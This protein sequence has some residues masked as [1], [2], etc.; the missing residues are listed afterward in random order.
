MESIMRHL[1]LAVTGLAFSVLAQAQQYPARPVKIVTSFLPGSSIDV[2]ARTIAQKLSDTWHQAVT[3]ESHPGGGG[4]GSVGADYVAKSPA[5]GYTWML[6]PNSVMIIGPHLVK[7]PFD[8]FKDFTPAGQVAM[9]PFLL[10]V[11][12]S[13][14]VKNVAELVEY[15][16]ANPR[17]LNYGSAGNG[18][19][20][21]LGAELIKR[22]SGI[23]M[24]HVPYK[25]STQAI[26]DLL[27]GR[28]QVFVGAATSLFP[29]I[30][31][32]K[33]KLL[34]SADNERLPAFPDVPTI[35]ETLPG[36]KVDAWLGIFMP[37]GV[38]R[39]I[40]SKVYADISSA[41]NTPE[42]KASLT[43]QG[44]EV[45]LSSPEA[46]AATMR[47]D[48]ARWGRLIQEASIKAD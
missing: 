20:H 40:V 48:Y 38:A 27:G 21:H 3:V 16:K 41:L 37:A 43:A 46:L 22:S 24:V 4:T 5:D 39:E 1:L 33:L 42:M 14:P 28:L 35:A 32:G 8:V 31:D 29:H 45:A 34:A 7:V 15:A 47:N 9:I 26:A 25:G 2:M 30:K 36:V 44:I 10:V 18:S 12:P 23:D 17:K 13:V 11:T 6:A 19:P